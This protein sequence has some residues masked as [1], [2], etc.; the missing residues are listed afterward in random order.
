MEA[1]GMAPPDPPTRPECAPIPIDGA[2]PS[3]FVSSGITNNRAGRGISDHDWPFS[4][5]VTH[6]KPG[7]TD[8]LCPGFSVGAKTPPGGNGCS[9]LMQRPLLEEKRS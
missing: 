1:P 2:I 5:H 7:T 3:P 8:C 6:G 4:G 9:T